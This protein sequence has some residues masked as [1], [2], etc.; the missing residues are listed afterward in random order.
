[1]KNKILFGILVPYALIL[2]FHLGILYFVWTF[3]K[4][5]SVLYVIAAVI[6]LSLV[7]FTVKVVRQ[8]LN[9]M[10]YL[11]TAEKLSIELTWSPLA[12]SS[13]AVVLN[14]YDLDNVFTGGICGEGILKINGN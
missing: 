10:G 9:S 12:V 1:M 2:I 3:I 11:K 8:Y 4:D 6:L 5:L 14:K 13:S 7:L